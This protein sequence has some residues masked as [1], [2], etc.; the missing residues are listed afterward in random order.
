MKKSKKEKERRSQ[1]DHKFKESKISDTTRC[2]MYP[3]AEKEKVERQ[4][5][6]NNVEADSIIK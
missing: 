5:Q 2:I 4:T 1:E 6:N 3:E